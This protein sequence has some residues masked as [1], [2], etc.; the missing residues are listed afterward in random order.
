MNVET[1]ASSDV[2]QNWENINFA[3]ARVYVKKLQM[4][5]VKAQQESRHNK[6]KTLQWM[7]THS[8]YAKALAVKRVTENK[9]KDTSGV[10]HELWTTPAAKFKAISKLKRRGYQPKPLKRV[11]I[12]KSNGKKRPLSIPTMTDRA[13]QTLYKFALEPIAETTADPNSYGFRSGR[14][15]QDA[16]VQ[17]YIALGQPTAAKW[18]LEGDIKGCFDNINHQ[19]IM[20]HIPMDKEILR[21]FLKCGYIETG[22][23][24]PTEVGAPQGGAISPTICNMV[25]DGIERKLKEKYYATTRKGTPIN[26]KVNFIRYADD[27][28]VTGENK[29]L[30]ETGVLPIIKEFMAERGLTLSPEKTVITHIDDGFDFLGCNIR[31]YNGKLLTKPSKE[32]TKAFLTKVRK[33]IKSNPSIKQEELIRYLNPIINGWVNYHKFNVSSKAFER[34]DYEIWRCLWQWAKRRN[35]K[36]GHRWVAKRY[37]H[38]IGNR[39]WTFS[40]PTNRKMA[41]GEPVY[42]R[43]VYA[44]DTNIRRF[45]KIKGKANPFD[46][47]YT[48]HFEER[49][50]DKLRISLK[51]R[52]ILAKLFYEQKGFCPICGEKITVD[53]NY[54]VHEEQIGNRKIKS[55]VHPQCHDITHSLDSQVEPVLERGL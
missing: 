43:L 20:E 32:N 6:V 21:K 53:T 51:G 3:K 48:Q 8:F 25:L 28:I 46:A 7:L 35:L 26:P 23:L 18:I 29:E 1:C 50:T 40:V 47:K 36:K 24:F 5:I 13:M 16:I 42:L 34:V 38:R 30:L 10:D 49:E 52:N 27:F 4:R 55:M 45:T 39:N 19:W 22:S 54:K 33:V 14:C 2:T 37:F 15:T 31:K 44:T 17:C 41:N 11:Y 12:P 9:G